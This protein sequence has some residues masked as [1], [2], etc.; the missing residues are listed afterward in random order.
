MT[1]QIVLRSPSLNR[2]HPLLASKST[3]SNCSG[4]GNVRFA[5]VVGG[6]TADCA[7]VCCCCPCGIVNLLVLAVYRLPAGIYRKAL[8][9][10]RRR[11]LKKKGLLPP[12]TSH[13]NCEFDDAEFQIHPISVDLSQALT[14]MPEKSLE[15]DKDVLELEKEMWDRFYSTGFW[16][17]PSQRE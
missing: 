9:K 15:S 14:D 5:E 11:R 16:R 6:T 7:A 8:R 4:G 17:S 10:S 13:C 12:K 1:R 3:S 2:R